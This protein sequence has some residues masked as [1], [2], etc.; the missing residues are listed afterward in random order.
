MANPGTM[1]AKML[2]RS[3]HQERAEFLSFVYDQNGD[4]MGPGEWR[5][6]SPACKSIGISETSINPYT[7]GGRIGQRKRQE[8]DKGT[9]Y[10]VVCV[11]EVQLGEEL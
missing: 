9:M 6:S 3:F 1:S 10:S 2:T 11:K 4:F 5:Q 8:T 7:Q